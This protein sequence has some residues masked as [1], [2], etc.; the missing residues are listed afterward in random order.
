MDSRFFSYSFTFFVFSLAYV[1]MIRYLYN[2]YEY[3]VT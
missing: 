1:K 2:H 3:Y